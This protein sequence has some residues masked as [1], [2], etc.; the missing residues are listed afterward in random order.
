MHTSRSADNLSYGGSWTNYVGIAF[1]G[2]VTSAV[3]GVSAT[4]A[5]Y[6]ME[7]SGD[8]SLTWSV[9]TG[10]IDAGRPMVFFVDSNGDGQID[11]AVAAIGYRTD[12]DVQEYACLDTWYGTVRWTAFRGVS[13]GFPF[14]VWG[15]T[16]LSLSGTPGAD[17]TPPLTQVHGADSSWHSAPVT[18]TFAPTDAGLGV[19]RTETRVDDEVLW[20]PGLTR[21]V[22]G[23]G[24]HVVSYRSVDMLANMEKTRTCT[25]KIDARGPRTSAV[26]VVASRGHVVSLAYR[27]A[28]LTPSARVRIVITRSGSAARKTIAVGNRGT[29]VWRA[30]RFLCTLRRGTY[31]YTV[32]ATDLAGNRQAAAGVARLVVR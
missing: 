2:Y 5:N 26:P 19:S 14:G 28:D 8:G 15:A 13:N 23:Q 32:Y 20:T 17:V 22:S 4:Y 16:S 29:G 3:P 10:E 24:V 18:L 12:G 27:V 30:C 25:V 6:F 7:G 9:L 31:R 1:T 11:H 21:T